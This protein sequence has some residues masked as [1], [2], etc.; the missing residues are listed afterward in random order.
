MLNFFGS[1]E[2]TRQAALAAVNNNAV[3]AEAACQDAVQETACVQAM[4]KLAPKVEVG[5]IQTFCVNDP[6]IRPCSGIPSPTGFSRFLVSQDICVQIQ[7]TFSADIEA[8]PTGIS[9]GAPGVGPRARF[10][11]CT[12]TIGYYKNHPEVT[13]SLIVLAGGSVILGASDIGA[14]LT[15]TTLNAVNVLS[16]NNPSPPIPATAPLSNQ[17]QVLYAQLLAAKLNVLRGAVCDAATAA[18]AAADAF[19]ASSVSGVG[20]EGADTVQEPLAA[21][22]EGAADGCPFHCS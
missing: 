6:L 3:D 12:Y 19:I 21:Y 20:K 2:E 10:T 22:N 11:S 4:V 7:L 18:I 9:C 16:F 8:E 15:V 14:S 5:E 17:Y 13:N 1:K